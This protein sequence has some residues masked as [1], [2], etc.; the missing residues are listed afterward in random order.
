MTTFEE[1]LR[2][3]LSHAYEIERELGGGGMSRVFVATDRSLGRRVV[4]KLLSPELTA[5]VNSERFR[6]EIQVAAQ[7]QHPHIVT[8]LSAGEDG[9]IFYY[10]MPY[11]EG[12]SLRSALEK[13]GAM[14]VREVIRVMCDV[15]DALGYAHARGVVHRD[16]KPGNILRSGSH[17]LVTDFG[18]AKALNAAMPSSGITSTGV[19]IGT[20][21]YMAPEQLAGDPAAD[22][23]LDIYAVGLLAYE[24]LI[25]QSP[26]SA[27]SPQATMAAQ[28]TRDPE[29]LSNFRKDV[30]PALSAIIMK[31]LAKI[32]DDRY[33]NAT[34]LSAALDAVVLGS[35]E[36]KTGDQ[37]V[38][39]AVKKRRT[40]FVVGGIA[41]LI[42]APT[43][44]LLASKRSAS[45]PVVKT[46][47]P[48]APTFVAATPAAAPAA[49]TVMAAPTGPAVIT[50]ADSLA[51]EA[52]VQRRLTQEQAQAQAAA[53]KK[54]KTAV[55]AVNE[56]SIRK[57]MQ[58]AA[59]D[60]IAR[61]APAAAP[62]RAVVVPVEPVAPAPNAK[63]RVA[64][65]EPKEGKVGS[66]NTFS[67][68]LTEALRSS[69]G[70][71]GGFIL[72]DQ[73]SVTNALANSTNRE[74]IVKVLQP[75]VLITHTFAGVGVSDTVSVI[76]TIRDLRSGSSFGIRVTSAKMVAANAEYYV[77]PVLQSI[78]KQVDD[79]SRAP[80]IYRK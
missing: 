29:P 68:T 48:P 63:K 61:A 80:S 62:P 59:A 5:G 66:L 7:L 25:G 16:I 19:A 69:L 32:P 21:A 64:I 79:L 53:L 1:R 71:E 56:D 72:I 67:H 20:P 43:V 78:L 3:T 22:H 52:A 11:I 26:F 9:D 13:H 4:I 58:K 45:D 35:G 23:R 36:V 41:V 65:T 39:P 50:K 76:V 73:D 14:T 54:G 60:S 18:V 6:R 38:L 51:I 10:T 57:A 8:L 49:P 34:A 46:S 44:A 15:V 40:K 70:R 12:E 37:V 17:A 2:D 77:G 75:D 74:D 28:L 33:Q 30:P 47:T 42:L 27:L 55:V 31:C 24:L